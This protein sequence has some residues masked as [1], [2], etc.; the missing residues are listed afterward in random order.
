MKT[1]III[2][3][4]LMGALFFLTVSLTNQE[5]KYYYAFNEKTKLISKPN[6][7][8]VKYK[9]GKNKDES[10][11]FIKSIFC[12][13]PAV[14]RKQTFRSLGNHKFGRKH[15]FRSAESLPSPDERLSATTETLPLPENTLSANRKP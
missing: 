5:E 14:G 9:K 13:K 6:V 15:T 7:L 1:R 3:L 8:L 2:C 11:T 12:G 4:V 10:D